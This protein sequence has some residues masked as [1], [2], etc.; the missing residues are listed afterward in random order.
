VRFSQLPPE[1]TLGLIMRDLS[2]AVRPSLTP[3]QYL[4]FV[5][6]DDSDFGRAVESSGIAVFQR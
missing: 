5:V 1:E 6:V 4:D 2:D 3:D